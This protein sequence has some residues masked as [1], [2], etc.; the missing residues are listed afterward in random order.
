MR[1]S[2]ARYRA[3]FDD[4]NTAIATFTLDGVI[5]NVNRAAARMLGWSRE[6]MV[7]QHY[8]TFATPTSVA[9]A[10]ER[11]RRFLAGEKL[12]SATFEAELVRK[13]GSLLQVEARTRAIRDQHNQ[14]VG[15]QGIYRDITARKQLDTSCAR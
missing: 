12:P 13:D 4:A 2:E 1:E 15:F 11:T 7:G 6:E 5:T 10:E 8:G 14:I 3:L 9:L